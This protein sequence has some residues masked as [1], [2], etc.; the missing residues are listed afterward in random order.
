MKKTLSII[1]VLLVLFGGGYLGWNWY[2]QP[3][4]ELAP[5][6]K[7][8]FEDKI[9]AIEKDID[10]KNPIAGKTIYEGSPHKMGEVVYIQGVGVSITPLSIKKDITK[11][12]GLENQLFLEVGLNVYNYTNKPFTLNPENITFEFKKEDGQLSKQDLSYSGFEKWQR[13]KGSYQF[14]EIKSNKSRKGSIYTPVDMAAQKDGNLTV[15]IN[16]VPVSFKY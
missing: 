14:G 2:T 5:D 11:T 4:I 16:R 1:L 3:D 10:P 6:E 15:Y 9:A 8:E 13:I 12:E 7:F